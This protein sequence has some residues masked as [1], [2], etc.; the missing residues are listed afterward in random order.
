MENSKIFREKSLEQL[1]TPEQLTGYLKVTGPGVWVTLIGV[2]VLL[3]GLFFW[4]IMGTVISTVR[5]PA[6]VVNGQVSCYV[7][8]ENMDEHDKEVDISIGDVSVT[9]STENLESRTMVP[10]DDRRL[11]AS[12]YLSA[13]KNVN[14]LTAD[15]TLEDGFYEAEVTVEKLKP[16]SL[17]FSQK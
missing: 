16:I 5:V 15:T 2:I 8:T 9:A 11:Y 1:N 12:G 17:L 4:G 7:L 6:Q 10:S 13:G 14:V 3:C